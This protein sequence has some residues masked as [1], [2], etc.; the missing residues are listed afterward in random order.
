MQTTDLQ[1]STTKLRINDL[2]P[3]EGNPRQMTDAQAVQLK[4]SLEKFNL[5][6]IP[7]VNTNGKILAGHQRLKIM[8]ILGRGQE[9]I[10]CRIPN[11]LLTP[12]EEREYLLRSNKNTGEWDFDALANFD[13]EL[14]KTIGFSSKE[15][16]RIF[17]LKGGD[18]DDAPDVPAT[19]RAERGKV[20]Q[21]GEHRVM[22]G[23]STDPKDVATLMQDAKADM[24][25]TDPPYNVN[26]SGEGKDTSNTIENDNRPEQAFR[27]LLKKA[28]ENYRDFSN[29]NAALYCCYGVRSQSEFEDSLNHAGWEV[30]NQIIW[31][32]AVASMGWGDYR[33]K[34]EP[35]FY[36]HQKGS[37]LN[38]Y[39]DRCQYTEWTEQ[40]TDAELLDLFKKLIEKD[41]KGGS[42]V[43]RFSR[44]HNYK[45]PTQKPV[46]LVKKAITNS[47][48][49]GEI[50][51][52]L[53]GGSGSTLLACDLLKR[54]CRTMEL[55]PKYVDVIIERWC[56]FTGNDREAVYARAQQPEK[57]P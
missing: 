17:D 5:V 8:Q 3:F 44:E 25:F 31:V 15:L 46:E 32:K 23:D 11:R 39:G 49:R 54:Q 13:E 26:Y 19:A 43:W 7:A 47:S 56:T 9:L 27:D 45:H 40:K 20:Y 16:D 57:Q 30:K 33:Q 22:C 14:L 1:W 37:K 12:E 36:A 55:D 35:M 24:V 21:L 48:Q 10:D 4:Q 2:I 52:D 41:E 18:E 28:F 42:T 34:H 50:V 51:L 53:F 38:F 29:P 6:E